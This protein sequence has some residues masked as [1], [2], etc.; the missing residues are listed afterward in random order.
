MKKNLI[1]TTTA[2][3]V[4]A[5]LTSC[6]MDQVAGFAGGVGVGGLLGGR[7]A[8]TALAILAA[9]LIT[10]AIVSQYQA[11]QEQKRYAQARAY[12]AARSESFAAVRTKKKVRYVAVPVK[13]KSSKEKSGLML[14]DAEKGQLESDKVFVPQASSIKGNTI[15]EVDGKEA[16]LASGF[17]GA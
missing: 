2:V 15:V 4:S 8:G 13:S 1:T 5:L 10:V 14:Y 17:S 6:T 7:H 11:S 12:A 9:G 3:T 16:M